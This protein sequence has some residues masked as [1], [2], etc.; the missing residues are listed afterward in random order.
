MALGGIGGGTARRSRA[1]AERLAADG[2]EPSEELHALLAHRPTLWAS[3]VSTLL[4]LAVVVLMVWRP[5]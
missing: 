4:I 2:D 5:T 3:Y 1:L